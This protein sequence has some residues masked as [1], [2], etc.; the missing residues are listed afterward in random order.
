MPVTTRLAFDH[1]RILTDALGWL[2]H[3]VWKGTLGVDLLP[4]EFTTEELRTL[5]MET[6]GRGASRDAKAWLTRAARAGHVAAQPAR[7]LFAVVNRSPAAGSPKP[8]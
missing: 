1:D 7:G 4:D 2:A 5:L 8:R 6:T 3:G